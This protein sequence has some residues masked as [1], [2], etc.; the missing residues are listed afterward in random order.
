MPN[1]GNIPS[2]EEK[3]DFLKKIEEEEK[4]KMKQ[5]FGEG[6]NPAPAGGN[7]N[8]PNIQNQEGKNP[9]NANVNQSP[10]NQ[11]SQPVQNQQINQN[12]VQNTQGTPQKTEQ[13][14]VFQQ[15]KQQSTSTANP[16]KPKKKK[17]M[18]FAA[19]FAT[20]FL[21]FLIVVTLL[22]FVLSVGG[23]GNPVLQF[24]GQNEDS[25]KDFL[26]GLVNGTFGFFSVVLLLSITISLF[27]GFS[28]S[29]EE[30]QKRRSAF[31]FSGISFILQFITV[32]AWLG[33]F[34]Y[35]DSLAAA[36]G[37]EE[38]EI[39]MMLPNGDALIPPITKEET[40]NLTVPVDLEFSAEKIEQSINSRGNMI[41]TLQW[42][43]TGREIYESETKSRTRSQRFVQAGRH[44]VLVKINLENG[45]EVIKNIVFEIPQGTFS[46]K[47]TQGAIPLD[48]EFDATAISNPIPSIQAFEWDFDNDFLYEEQTKGAIVTHRFET[49]GTHTVNLKIVDKSGEI[50]KFS[51]EVETTESAYDLIS[52]K[53]STFPA[54]TD[55]AGKKLEIEMGT[56]VQ[57]D[58]SESTSREGKI[59]S[60]EWQFSDQ[61]QKKFGDTINRKFTEEGEFEVT[62][63]VENSEGMESEDTIIV[64]T[65]STPTAPKPS[66]ITT[67]RANE[68][69]IVSGTL[70]L[71]VTFDASS[72]KD[73]DNNITSYEWDF[74]KDGVTDEN[75][76][77]IEHTFREEGLYTVQ[78]TIRDA[79]NQEGTEEVQV[80]VKKQTLSA[81]II[82]TPET[83]EMP[84]EISFD[85]SLS[86]CSEPGCEII[87]YEWNFGD[88]AGPQLMGA[89]AVRRFSHIGQY[90]INLTVY[91]NQDTQSSD[92]KYVYCRET[93]LSSCFNASRTTGTVP[94]TVEFDASCSTGIIQ[95][96]SWDFGDGTLSQQRSPTHTFRK[97]GTHEVTLTIIDEKNNVDKYTSEIV[98]EKK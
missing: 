83:A 87:A 19:L 85:G 29:K 36:Q 70:P 76:S 93:P 10:E 77:E 90:E 41:D 95:K 75:G 73:E 79:D 20:T 40:A 17:K 12:P 69:N 82:T 55:P 38:G 37:Q 62:L 64:S 56:Q 71:S 66:I 33:M 11:K 13:K 21:L 15:Q 46:I 44:E 34:N 59:Q 42:D 67:P 74:D 49:I 31:I 24:F 92:S 48:V 4:A 63:T 22:I 88:G 50:Y 26:L 3:I 28:L 5:V 54:L 27:F 52:S 43:F 23:A 97:D 25:V 65:I 30:K 86:S 2:D 72:S 68:E 81:Q 96:W 7:L 8:N 98:A 45:N 78:L 14:N 1:E 47:P 51:G 32:L 91:T 16:G 60:Y 18:S 39:I 53:I 94:M 57:F 80:E 9:Q 58:G 6:Q 89:H 35:V 61:P 84:C